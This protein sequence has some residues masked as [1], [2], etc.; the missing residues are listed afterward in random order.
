MGCMD[1]STS[2]TW[3][4]NVSHSSDIDLLVLTEQFFQLIVSLEPTWRTFKERL[5]R[6]AKISMVADISRRSSK[7]VYLSIGI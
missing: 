1:Q 4:G 5:L 2:G 3:T 7:K 6:F